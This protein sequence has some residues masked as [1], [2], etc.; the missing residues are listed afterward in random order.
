MNNVRGA[1][2]P[3]RTYIGGVSFVSRNNIQDHRDRGVQSRERLIAV[4]GCWFGV[5][6]PVYTED[7]LMKEE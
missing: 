5:A 1:W 4:Q 3:L 2:G 6:L 7:V